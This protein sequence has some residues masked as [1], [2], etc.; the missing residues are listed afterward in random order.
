MEVYL[1]DADP[2]SEEYYSEIWIPV[3]NRQT[4]FNYKLERWTTFKNHRKFG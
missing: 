3:K 2:Y 4:K 1:S